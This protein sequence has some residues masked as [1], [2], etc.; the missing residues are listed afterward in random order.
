MTSV[1]Q[2]TKSTKRD[3]NGEDDAIK[4]DEAKERVLLCGE[5]ISMRK[6]NDD[7]TSKSSSMAASLWVKEKAFSQYAI[8]NDIERS[9][10]LGYRTY[11]Q[12][13]C[14]ALDQSEI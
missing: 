5:V 10:H 2:E 7:W 9:F 12:R 14:N 1:S 4:K 3:V 11:F 8:S 13:Y 6:M